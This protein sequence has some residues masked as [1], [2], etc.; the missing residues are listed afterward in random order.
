M[1]FKVEKLPNE[2]VILF[3]IFEDYDLLSEIGTAHQMVENL[4]EAQT[5]PVF[6][7]HEIKAP[8]SLEELIVGANPESHG[9]KPVW[10]HPNVRKFIVITTNAA[11]LAA[12]EG[13][14][15]E[16]F[17]NINIMVVGTLDEALAHVRAQQ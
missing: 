11:M 17:G 13:M 14:G 7:V 9:R 5:A 8:V 3:T 16:A 1:S 2:P 10:Q 6:L 4:L 12:A 15:S